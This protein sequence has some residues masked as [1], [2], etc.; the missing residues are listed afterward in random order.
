VGI[1]LYPKHGTS[2]NKLYNNADTAMYKAKASGKKC[3]VFFSD[4]EEQLKKTN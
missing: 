4:S 3:F 1:A 2:Y